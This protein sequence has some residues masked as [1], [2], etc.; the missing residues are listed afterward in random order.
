VK[1]EIKVSQENVLQLKLNYSGILDM[2]R[3]NAPSSG[4]VSQAL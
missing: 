4:F 1:N 2:N 3:Q